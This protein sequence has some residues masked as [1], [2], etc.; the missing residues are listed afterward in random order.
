MS[1][2]EVRH[3][4]KSFGA[5]LVLDDVNFFV[6]AGASVTLDPVGATCLQIISALSPR[7]KIFG[8]VL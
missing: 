8:A 1:V 5:K 3:V 4:K 6:D 2:L 7:T